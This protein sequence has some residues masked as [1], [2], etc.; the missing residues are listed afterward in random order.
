MWHIALAEITAVKE[1][2]FLV[3]DD[4]KVNQGRTLYYNYKACVKANSFRCL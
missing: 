3:G 4:S 1:V 2:N